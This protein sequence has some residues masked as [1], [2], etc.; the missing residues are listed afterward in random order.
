M[1]VDRF[2]AF[3]LLKAINASGGPHGSGMHDMSLTEGSTMG[4]M[5]GTELMTRMNPS[6]AV[7]GRT[8]VFILRVQTN[9]NPSPEG[10]G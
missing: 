5:F 4:C 10:R 2:I 1:V 8:R 3:D 6:A 7:F 9:T